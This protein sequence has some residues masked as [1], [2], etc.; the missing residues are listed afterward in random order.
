MKEQRHCA[1]CANWIATQATVLEGKKSSLSNRGECHRYAP[2]P[3]I[4]AQDTMATL[5]LLWPITN[6]SDVCG[7]WYYG[8]YR[9]EQEMTSDQ[10]EAAPITQTKPSATQPT[11]AAGKTDSPNRPRND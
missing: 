9:L 11:T 7:E 3:L 5:A 6:A 8:G 10:T 2:R 4:T 1:T